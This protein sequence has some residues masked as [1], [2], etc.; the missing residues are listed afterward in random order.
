MIRVH[1]VVAKNLRNAAERI[2]TISMSVISFILGKKYISSMNSFEVNCSAFFMVYEAECGTLT[3][4]KPKRN[5]VL[6]YFQKT[7]AYR[8]IMNLKSQ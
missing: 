2:Y 1:V 5:E 6:I 7:I 4:T 8:K 3:F